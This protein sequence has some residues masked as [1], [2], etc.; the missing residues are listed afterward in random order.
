[1]KRRECGEE[2]VWREGSMERKEC[3]EEEGGADRKEGMETL[4][5]INI[6]RARQ[7]TQTTLFSQKRKKSCS[8]GIRTHNTLL[9]RQML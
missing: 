6:K 3:G 5:P 1:M 7:L 2:G 9:A 8:G 4:R